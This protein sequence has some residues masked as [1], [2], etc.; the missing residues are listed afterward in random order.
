M[1]SKEKGRQT[2]VRPTISKRPDPREIMTFTRSPFF[3]PDDNRNARHVDYGNRN[4]P[5]ITVA[6]VRT[7][8]ATEIQFR[9]SFL[10]FKLTPG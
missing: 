4:H 7:H 2:P 8:P 6:R 5:L 9:G 1:R 10:A 3:T